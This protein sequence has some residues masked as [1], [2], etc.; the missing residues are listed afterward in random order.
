MSIAA[1]REL[2]RMQSLQN[3]RVRIVADDP[4]E[5]GEAPI[6]ASFLSGREVHVWHA[7]LEDLAPAEEL[8]GLLSAEE[9]GRA[10][11]FYQRSRQEIYIRAHG[12][13]RQVLSAYAG[14]SPGTIQYGY[15]AYGKPYLANARDDRKVRFNMSHD[16]QS[17]S[18]I[19]SG[20]EEVGIDAEQADPAFDWRPIARAYFAPE[21]NSFLE[22]LPEDRR[23][24]AFCWIWTRKEAL[25]KADGAGL[26]A[27]DRC[28]ASAMRPRIGPFALSTWELAPDYPC[29][30]AVGPKVEQAIVMRL[31]RKRNPSMEVMGLERI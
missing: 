5:P 27:I 13:L 2:S 25:L 1:K 8:A 7:R 18:Y 4:R 6:G 16:G 11:S 28:A 26:S 14:L 23:H 20:D 19:V 22:S 12:T 17:V 29:S 3:P 30:C 24:Y 21:E 9:L 10:R 15:A 31:L